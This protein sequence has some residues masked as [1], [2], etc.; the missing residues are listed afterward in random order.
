MRGWRWVVLRCT[1]GFEGGYEKER[2]GILYE[3]NWDI[4]KNAK[5]EVCIERTC[6]REGG[7]NDTVKGKKK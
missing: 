2:A 5:H 6:D 3:N 7:E 1:S 4:G